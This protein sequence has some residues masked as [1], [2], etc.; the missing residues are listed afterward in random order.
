MD[1]GHVHTQI[2]ALS[3]CSQLRNVSFY[4]NNFSMHILMGLLELTANLSRL[5]MEEY[6]APL[7]CYNDLGVLSTV[8]FAQHSAQLMGTLRDIRQPKSISFATEICHTCGRCYVYVQESRLC[9]CWQ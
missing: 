7:E 6:P 1:A 9:P 8:L 2:S 4:D 5:I 3:H